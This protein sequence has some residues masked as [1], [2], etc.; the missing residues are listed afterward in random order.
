M[1]TKLSTLNVD[2]VCRLLD[3]LDD[4]SPVAATNYKSVLHE[5][6]INGR[7]LL[8]CDLDELKKILKMNFGDWE[9]FRVMI[10]SLREHEMTTVIK[11][12][13]SKNTVRFTVSKSTTPVVT[14]ERRGSIKNTMSS[15]ETDGGKIQN[16]NMNR[17]KQSVIEK[18]VS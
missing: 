17:N 6:N 8:H 7:V 2:G 10:V 5:N 11:Q 16:D 3:N 12:D 13:E 18:Q 14:K 4:L 15:N 9:M 1:D